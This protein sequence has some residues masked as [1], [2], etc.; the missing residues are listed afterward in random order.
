MFFLL[1]LLRLIGKRAKLVSL[2]RTHARTHARTHPRTHASYV[3]HARTLEAGVKRRAMRAEDSAAFHSLTLE[4]SG[5]VQ[6]VRDASNE[7]TTGTL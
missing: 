6:S 3:L 1:S 2:V 4:S 5:R 7:D